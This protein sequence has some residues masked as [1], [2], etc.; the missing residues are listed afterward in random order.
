MKN[1]ALI[2]SLLFSLTVFS[3]SKKEQIQA[4]VIKLDST[5]SVLNNEREQFTSKINELEVTNQKQVVELGVKEGE[6]KHLNQTI[7]NVKSELDKSAKTID[8]LTKTVQQLQTEIDQLKTKIADL[9][10][11]TIKVIP[12]TNQESVVEKPAAT[13]SEQ[14]KLMQ[15]LLKNGKLFVKSSS[16]TL[17]YYQNGKKVKSNTDTKSARYPYE[18]DIEMGGIDSK[19]KGTFFS[20]LIHDTDY[21]MDSYPTE[22]DRVYVEG[23]IIRA[24]TPN[25]NDMDGYTINAVT[26]KD[27]SITIEEYHLDTSVYPS[28]SERDAYEKMVNDFLTKNSKGNFKL[29]SVETYK[30]I[31]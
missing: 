7:L 29:R 17:D 2:S 28:N 3:Q 19:N 18:I 1:I 20:I 16:R 30:L 21:D 14:S 11:P 23:N 13:I 31:K 9:S 10:K 5:Q 8:E 25:L 22:F 24:C 15:Q 4:L 27:E 12:P 6:I 26:L